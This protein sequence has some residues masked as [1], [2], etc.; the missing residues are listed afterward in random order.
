MDTIALAFLAAHATATFT[1]F[2][3]VQGA[4]RHHSHFYTD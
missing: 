4:M 2:R 1:I 3:Y